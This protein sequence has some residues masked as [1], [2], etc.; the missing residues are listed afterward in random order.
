VDPQENDPLLADTPAELFTVKNFGEPW[1]FLSFHV[2]GGV[3]M[4]P[5]APGGAE[6]MASGLLRNG[7]RLWVPSRAGPQPGWEHTVG[8]SGALGYDA[9]A[10]GMSLRME[11]S[12]THEA[13]QARRPAPSLRI[14]GRYRVVTDL[15]LG[16]TLG[17]R[18][19]LDFSLGSRFDPFAGVFVRAGYQWHPESG[20][21]TTVG[22]QSGWSAHPWIA[23]A[24][25]GASVGAALAVDS[26][27]E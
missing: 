25:A 3:D 14:P 7:R 1:S 23:L 21:Y 19:G 13:G 11:L 8:V 24:L 12:L 15:G 5:A 26:L 4:L 2:L 20:M 9:G 27:A 10:H 18:Q 17:A 16:A 6:L 22:V